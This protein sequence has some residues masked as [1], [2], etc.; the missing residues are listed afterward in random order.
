MTHGDQ[1]AASPFTNHV[2]RTV[3]SMLTSLRTP[4]GPPRLG[5]LEAV[6]FTLAASESE[7]ARG[8]ARTR[9]TSQ[10]SVIDVN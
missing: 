10:G 9:C 1:G 4:P 5:E 3:P 2:A 8:P 7:S 6:R